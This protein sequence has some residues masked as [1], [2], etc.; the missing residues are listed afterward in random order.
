MGGR[1]RP[2]ELC[3]IKPVEGGKLLADVF[4]HGCEAAWGGH[5]FQGFEVELRQ[6]DPVPV[7]TEEKVFHPLLHCFC[8]GGVL[9]VHKLAPVE[10]GVL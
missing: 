5:P 1:S 4:V 10:F 3:G 8:A 9:E 7:E 2:K 6:V